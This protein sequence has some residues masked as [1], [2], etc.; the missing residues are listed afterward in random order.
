VKPGD[1]VIGVSVSHSDPSVVRAAG[2][3]GARFVDTAGLGSFRDAIATE[4]SVALVVL[5]R[6]AV[7][8]DLLPVEAIETIVGLAH[9][10]GALVYVDDAGDARVGPSAFGQPRT[11]ELGV[12]LSAA[13]GFQRSRYSGYREL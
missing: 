5:T 12:D 8:Y 6:V 13:A 9:D 7:T 2:H 10:K 4:R 11:L 3:V 1:V